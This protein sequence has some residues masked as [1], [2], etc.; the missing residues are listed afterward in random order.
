[1][2]FSMLYSHL[3]IQYVATGLLLSSRLVEGDNH[4]ESPNPAISARPVFLIFAINWN[5]FY[6]SKAPAV[7]RSTAAL[8]STVTS[9]GT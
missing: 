3:Y 9:K 5:C 7:Q 6:T 1:M 4:T 2:R 8:H